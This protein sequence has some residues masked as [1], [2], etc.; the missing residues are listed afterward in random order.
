MENNTYPP[1][2]LR[3]LDILELISKTDKPLSANDI[4][5]QLNLPIAS[6]YRLFRLLHNKQYI[7]SDSANKNKYVPGF[8]IL[9]LAHNINNVTDITMLARP[10]MRSIAEKTGQACM[11][12]VI[13]GD[14]IMV[15]DQILPLKPVSILSAVREKL[16]INVNPG[17]KVLTAFMPADEQNAFLKKAWRFVPSNTTNTITNLQRFKQEIM[18]VKERKYATDSEEYAIGIG[19]LSVPIFNFSGKVICALGITGHIAE[20]HNRSKFNFILNELI[21]HGKTFSSSLGYDTIIR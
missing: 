19:G 20:Y 11:L 2:A 7:V 21:K 14:G 13:H 4:A 18:L 17:G 3:I 16:S 12:I 8:K 5:K 10:S 15:I 6:V 1:S 9:E